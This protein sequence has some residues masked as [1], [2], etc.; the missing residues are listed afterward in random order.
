[1]SIFTIQPLLRSI[2]EM[3]KRELINDM[4]GSK[5]I[6]GVR[7]CRSEKEIEIDEAWGTTALE[8]SMSFCQLGIDYFGFSPLEH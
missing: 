4:A 2:L 5:L 7:R 3:Y 8:L 1:M 6:Q